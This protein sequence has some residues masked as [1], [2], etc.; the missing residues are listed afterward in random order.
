[1]L[2][3]FRPVRVLLVVLGL[4]ALG[5]FSLPSFGQGPL[6]AQGPAAQSARYS[7]ELVTLGPTLKVLSVLDTQTGAVKLYSLADVL[8]VQGKPTGR[9]TAVPVTMAGQ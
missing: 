1:M 9:F 4:G 5:A 2:T 3:R 6:Q 8:D 7:S